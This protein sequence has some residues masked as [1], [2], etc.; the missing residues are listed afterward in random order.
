MLSILLIQ[1]ERAKTIAKKGNPVICIKCKD[2][3]ALICLSK[4]DDSSY[5]LKVNLIIKGPQKLYIID[6]HILFAFSGYLP[7]ALSV[8]KFAKERGMHN[9][10]QY[11]I[12]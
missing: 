4:N 10:I 3:L 7:D 11:T 1:L 9:T 8:V 6:N 12:T 2:G 5:K